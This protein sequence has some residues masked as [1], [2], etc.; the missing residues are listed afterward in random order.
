MWRQIAKGALY[1]LSPRLF[2]WALE[3]YATFFAIRSYAHEGEDIIL[4]RVLSEKKNGFYVDVG[5]H[6]PVV[7]SN[8]FY[9]YKRGW[10]GINIEPNPALA[11]ILRKRRQRDITIEFGV[12]DREGT[13]EYFEFAVPG[14]NTFDKALVESRVR[15]GHAVLAT[16]NTPVRRLEAILDE[17]LPPGTEIDFMSIDVE[18]YDANVLRSNNWNRF[19]PKC[20]VVEMPRVIDMTTIVDDPLHQLLVA[21]SYICVAKTSF[22]AFYVDQKNDKIEKYIKDRHEIGRQFAGTQAG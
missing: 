8:T 9:F 11:Q 17:H 20:V 15:E 13:L 19:R 18:G 16:R 21:E 10:S 22:N 14:W 12:S 7:S 2:Y 6:H 1:R 5:A 3:K 4:S